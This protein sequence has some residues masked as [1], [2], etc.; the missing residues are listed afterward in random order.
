M[1]SYFF[2]FFFPFSSL[3]ATEPSVYFYI[4]RIKWKR[5]ESTSFR[6]DKNGSRGP[7]GFFIQISRRRKAVFRGTRVFCLTGGRQRESQKNTLRLHSFVQD[8][9]EKVYDAFKT[10][11]FSCFYCFPISQ[12]FFFHSREKKN[13]YASQRNLCVYIC[14]ASS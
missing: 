2:F 1:Q 12:F 14:C 13:L 6:S 9:P 5:L 3:R 11:D 7:L 4:C 10:L 8:H